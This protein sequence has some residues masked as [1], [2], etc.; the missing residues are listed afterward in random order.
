M[1]EDIPLNLRHKFLLMQDDTPVH[2]ALDSKLPKFMF[3]SK[4]EVET[5]ATK[6]LI[7]R[8][9]NIPRLW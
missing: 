1:K 8:I 3:S 2:F 4:L 9:H 5:N 7:T 6:L